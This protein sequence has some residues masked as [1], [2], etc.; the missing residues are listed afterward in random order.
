MITNKTVQFFPNTDE[1][2]PASLSFDLKSPPKEIV[3][4]VIL[5]TNIYS[6][7]FEHC[8]FCSKKEV[9]AKCCGGKK[10]VAKCTKLNIDELV[11]PTCLFCESYGTN[12]NGH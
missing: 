1:I 6:Y 12:S 10:T 2:D 7:K 5:A 9:K 11:A 3:R 4:D 8:I